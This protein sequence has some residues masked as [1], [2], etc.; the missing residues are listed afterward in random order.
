[1][2]KFFNLENPIFSF[3]NKFVD[4]LFLSVL[5]DLFCLPALFFGIVTFGNPEQF[6]V[7][8][9]LI[10]IL[11]SALIGP[12]LTALYYAVVKSVRRERS[13]AVREFFRAYKANF[14]FGA[15]TSVIFAVLGT[16]LFLDVFITSHADANQLSDTMLF[17]MTAVFRALIIILVMLGVYVFRVMSRFSMTYKTT[18]VSAFMMS[19][20]HL[21]TT[22][23]MAVIAIFFWLGP[24]FLAY[25][26]GAESL[27]QYITVCLPFF[28]IFPGL[29]N[30]LS[31]LV[32]EKVF[33]IYME[34]MMEGKTEEETGEDH[35]YM[36]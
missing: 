2:G 29:E 28:L 36:E 16:V 17:I 35:W 27:E 25:L 5:T 19:V 22:L 1:M 23:L 11:A 6:D 15:L 34:K 30:L 7:I 14:K 18:L 13:Y 32:L 12:A 26:L 33:K 21:P 4:L 10:F 20:R 8:S 31:S 9:A 3:I 24:V